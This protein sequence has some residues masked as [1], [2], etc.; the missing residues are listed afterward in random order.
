[1]RN[2]AGK[3]ARASLQARTRGHAALGWLAAAVGTAW[4][5]PA[6]GPQYPAPTVHD[7]DVLWPSQIVVGGVLSQG[8]QSRADVSVRPGGAEPPCPAHHAAAG[9]IA[10][11]EPSRWVV[12]AVEG[13]DAG[14]RVAITLDSALRPESG[15]LNFAD[16]ASTLA[17]AHPYRGRLELGRQQQVAHALALRADPFA[18]AS[19]KVAG[20]GWRAYVA[21]LA[22]GTRTDGAASYHSPSEHPLR[23]ALQLGRPGKGGPAERYREGAALLWDR[24]PWLAGVGWQRWPEGGATVPLVLAYDDGWQ[25]YTVTAV[26]GEA[27]GVAW[28]HVTAGFARRLMVR[29]DPAKAQLRLALSQHE[30]RG[31]AAWP[32]Q[33]RLGAGLRWRL[34]GGAWV[35]LNAGERRAAGSLAAARHAPAQR[36]IELGLGLQFERDLR[37][38]ATRASVA[39]APP[40][41]ETLVRPDDGAR[42]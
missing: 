34:G 20:P 15:C 16:N 23:F 3:G 33:V 36:A 26:R 14:W 6:P 1:L 10:S 25:R 28:R 4:A 19:P 5:Q 21:P 30:V 18:G 11:I 17:L 40:L 32:E 35:D 41:Y 37:R 39:P 38:S 13:L 42:P 2:T 24:L 12:R 31:G 8:L 27:D 9:R 29:G 7:R 22:G